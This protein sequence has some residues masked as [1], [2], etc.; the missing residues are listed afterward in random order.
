MANTQKESL[1]SKKVK[2]KTGLEFGV[3]N[4]LHHDIVSKTFNLKYDPNDLFLDEQG[5]LALKNIKEFGVLGIDSSNIYGYTISIK[6]ASTI[7]VNSLTGVPLCIRLGWIGT[8]LGTMYLLKSIS[9]DQETLAI[10]SITT[11][12]SASDVY[13][14][15]PIYDYNGNSGYFSQWLSDDDEDEVFDTLYSETK[16]SDY[17]TEGNTPSV[18]TELTP[19]TTSGT[20]VAVSAR[21]SSSEA[22][23]EGVDYDSLVVTGTPII[24]LTLLW[25]VNPVKGY[26]YSTPNPGTANSNA[27]FVVYDKQTKRYALATSGTILNLG[28]LNIGSVVS[29]KINSSDLIASNAAINILNVS[30]SLVIGTLNGILKAT[31]GVVSIGAIV[32]DDLDN[33]EITNVQNLDLLQYDEASGKWINVAASAISGLLTYDEDYKC[34]IGH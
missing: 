4:P 26:S 2:I 23:V 12:L 10:S 3:I 32:L 20:D 13:S 19:D 25:K 16:M 28:G 1:N 31:D 30:D 22:P 15:A 34:Y 14:A 8:P 11:F 18:L 24:E 6:D 29:F 33:I 7:A 17:L 5:R 21:L 9:F 27:N